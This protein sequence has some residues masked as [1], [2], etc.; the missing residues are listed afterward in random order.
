MN[1]ILLNYQ[2]SKSNQSKKCPNHPKRTRKAT[3]H[4]R[5]FSIIKDVTVVRD[6]KAIALG[7]SIHDQE[8]RAKDQ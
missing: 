7:L 8:T 3:R 1:R 5:T 4:P 6:A 2:A